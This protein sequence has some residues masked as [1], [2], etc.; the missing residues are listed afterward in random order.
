M[1]QKFNDHQTAKISTC[2]F[3]SSL[4]K[5]KAILESLIHKLK[6]SEEAAKTLTKELEVEKRK[7]MEETE[8]AEDEK[9]RVEDE[10]RRVEEWER[11][12]RGG[13]D[14]E[15]EGEHGGGAREPEGEDEDPGLSERET[16]G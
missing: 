12:E 7:A 5:D 15:T 1:S 4:E 10:K 9:R 16:D 3:H 13:G 6:D 8:R 14:E 2:I 11:G